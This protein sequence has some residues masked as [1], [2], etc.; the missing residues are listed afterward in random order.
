MFNALLI[1][2]LLLISRGW[3]WYH[4]PEKFA[5]QA[6]IYAVGTAA[7][8]WFILAYILIEKFQKPSLG[9]SMMVLGSIAVVFPYGRFL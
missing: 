7:V 2:S 9:W 1:W 8:I 5:L 3:I 6:P 4:D